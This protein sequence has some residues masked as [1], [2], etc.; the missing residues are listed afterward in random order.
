MR[1]E[2]AD[3]V[4]NIDGVFAVVQCTAQVEQSYGGL[5]AENSIE[6]PLRGGDEVIELDTDQLPDGEEVLNILNQE[7]A[8]LPIWINVAVAYYKKRLYDDF[9]K[10]LEEAYR[11]AAD[12]QPYQEGDLVRLLDMLANYYGRKAYKE[13]TKEKKNQLI[14]HATRLFTSADRIDMYD[15]KH[16]LGRAFFFIY[17]GENW[18]QAD[19]QLNFVLNQ[20]APSVPAY[21]GKACIA[22]NKKEY[23][24]ALGF[25]RKAL[26]L[27]P[28]CPASV[29]LGMGH[30]FFKLGNMEKARLAFQRALDLDP[31]CVGALVGLAIL[32]LNEKTQAIILFRSCTHQESIKQGVQ[33]LSRAYNLDPTNP[34]VL[35]HLADHFFYKKE[36]DKVQRLAL[37]AFYNTE[38][39]AMRAESCYQMARAFHMQENYDN[40][41]QY[42]YL[43]TQLA[44]SNFILPFYG[45]GQMYLHRNDLE[46]AAVSFERVLKDHPTNYETL[47]IL[48][49]LYSQSNK[50][51]KRAQAKQLFKQVTES[52]PEDV[53]AWIEYAQLLENDTNGALDAYLK[54]LT[55]LENIQLDVAPEILNN[56][57]CLYHMKNDHTQAMNFFTRALDR[58]QEEQQSEENERADG[59]VGHDDEYYHGLNITVRYNRARLHE[60][61]GRPDLAEEIYKSILLQHPSYIDCYLRLGCI[62]RDRGMIW[63]A[64]IWF[65]DALDIDPDH[66]DVWS[67]IG[68]LH[69]S[70][71]E[72]EQAQK[73]FDRI[74]RQP[75]Y[76]ADAFARISLG[77]IWLTTLHHPIRD[78][79]KRKRHQDRALSFYKAVLCADPRNIWAAH[80]IGCVLAHKGFVNEARDVFAQ[81]REATADFPDVWINIAHIYVEQKQYTAA[82][83]MY[84]NCLKKFSMQNNTELLQYLARAYFKAG[85]LKECKT[86]LLKA[87]HVKPWDQLLTFNLALVRK[88]LAVTVLQDE[89]SSFL[90]VCD[91]IADLNMARCTFDHLSK[92]NEVL[93][94]ALAADEARTCQD[95][96]SQAKY[97]LDRAKSREEQE[98][99]VRKRQEDEREAQR[100]RQIELQ[101]Q[102]EQ[103]R[104]ERERRLEEERGRFLEKA[105]QIVLEPVIEDRKGRKSAGG[106][107]KRDDFIA[108]EDEDSSG[109]PVERG[110]QHEGETGSQLKSKQKKHGTKRRSMDSRLAGGAR[111]KQ[112]LGSSRDDGLTAK[113][114]M[115]VVSK[116]IVS[117]SSDSS[118]DDDFN[119]ED[120][121]ARVAALAK[122]I[123][124][125]DEDDPDQ[126]V[127]HLMR[128]RQASPSSSDL[129]DN[130]KH[131]RKAH[132]RSR[133]E[134]VR[135]G[136]SRGQK[137]HNVS[138]EEEE[139][140]DQVRRT[141]AEDS[142]DEEAFRVRRPPSKSHHKHAKRDRNPRESSASS[143]EVKEKE[144]E[145]YDEDS[146]D[147]L[148]GLQ[149]RKRMVASS[150]SDE[151]D[152]DEKTK[153]RR[154]NLQSDDDDNSNVAP[155]D[156][157]SSALSEDEE[158]S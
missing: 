61:C 30:C 23:R 133:N 143:P 158:S 119:Q 114:R 39:E 81:V 155:A 5:A 144:V 118:S 28:N 111:K 46:H 151:A 8:P 63:D 4:W 140:E 115:R 95:L 17:E 66:P 123:L 157:L 41:F 49:S 47:K 21:L 2:Q 44:S 18:S 48:G 74:I 51:D 150:D 26:R 117:E 126:P 106:S 91:A 50:P 113:Q 134:R 79:D 11:N 148:V 124:S 10:V 98:R 120:E 97:H 82:I 27:Q 65:K 110:D 13:K 60:V 42:Y 105:K 108:S 12:L 33:R 52:Q 56:I 75:T 139:E 36:Y 130:H 152:N 57:A 125:S 34:M 100:K 132:K 16:L 76:R 96:L 3:L 71:N 43:A 156:D 99:V 145:D 59:G 107:R 14:A 102:A 54:A 147:G 68:L 127:E 77:N 24:N 62:A 58:I 149:K 121:E 7:K 69:L 1:G 87:M 38:T 142:S 128:H 9:E 19:S 93:N 78:K 64:S 6:I 101:K 92:S 141:Q 40:A 25:Y 84:E 109:S 122:K 116:A 94:Q 29:R 85:Q 89:T 32:D 67:L 37:H 86:M 55:I 88:R 80:G 20:G 45:L 129:S 131:S 137:R 73:K 31:D 104:L 72:A 135:S 22:F 15:Q 35:N 83:Q 154:A 70:K 138:S 90:S 112:R 136:R 103:M 53:E 153:P 146:D